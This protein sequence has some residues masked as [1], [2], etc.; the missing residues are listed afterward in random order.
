MNQLDTAIMKLL[1]DLIVMFVNR[2][3]R[4][5]LKHQIL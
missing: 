1:T 3:K 5:V 4:N 2:H